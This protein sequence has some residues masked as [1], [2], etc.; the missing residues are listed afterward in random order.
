MF[1]DK[2]ISEDVD[3]VNSIALTDLNHCTEIAGVADDETITHIV[4][5]HNIYRLIV[6][7]L[8]S[9][10]FLDKMRNA[11]NTTKII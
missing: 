9:L 10:A 3:I 6:E 2:V 11:T 4:A 5:R 7:L 8:S 1:S